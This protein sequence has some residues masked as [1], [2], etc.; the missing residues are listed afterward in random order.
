[1]ELIDSFMK[2][3]DY[4]Y[5]LFFAAIS[6]V[7]IINTLKNYKKLNRYIF[8]RNLILSFFMLYFIYTK[9]AVV[10]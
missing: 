10:L 6:I 7:V 3:L 5:I 9:T 8:F 4:I 1:V 2:I